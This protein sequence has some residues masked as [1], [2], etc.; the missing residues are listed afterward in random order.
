MLVSCVLAFFGRVPSESTFLNDLYL[1][2][3]GFEELC[4]VKRLGT[5]Y[6]VDTDVIEIDI[7]GQ[8]SNLLRLELKELKIQ[9]D[10]AV[11]LTDCAFIELEIIAP[12]GG[13]STASRIFLVPGILTVLG[14]NYLYQQFRG[15]NVILLK[16][17]AQKTTTRSRKIK[18][19]FRTSQGVVLRKELVVLRMGL[20]EGDLPLEY[21]QL[22]HVDRFA[23]L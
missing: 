2:M 22:P 11:V 21:H 7:P 12:S 10:P 18:I 15:N 13:L 6:D 8:T 9:L 20:F 14:T 4:V 17:N 19:Q 16:L 5:D 3:A 23:A 1:R